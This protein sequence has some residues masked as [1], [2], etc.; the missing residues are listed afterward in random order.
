M[1]RLLLLFLLL[2]SLLLSAVGVIKRKAPKKDA[3]PD[4][5]EYFSTPMHEVMQNDIYLGLT[6]DNEYA[7]TYSGKGADMQ[8]DD[9]ITHADSIKLLTGSLEE[10]LLS[11][12]RETVVPVVNTEDTKFGG[13]KLLGFVMLQSV[14]PRKLSSRRGDIDFDFEEGGPAPIMEVGNI[15]IGANGDISSGAEEYVPP[16]HGGG[17]CITGRDCFHYNGT[18]TIKGECVCPS[19]YTGSYCQIFKSEKSGLATLAEQTKMKF[20]IKAGLADLQES[21]KPLN[22]DLPAPP[23]DEDTFVKIDTTSDATP[24]LPREGSDE[25]DGEDEDFRPAR[26]HSP[27]PKPPEPAEDEEMVPIKMKPEKKVKVKPKANK[28]KN[29]NKRGKK[30]GSEPEGEEDEEVE[31]PKKKKKQ[32]KKEKEKNLQAR[33]SELYGNEEGKVYPEP[34]LA[35]KVPGNIA[36]EREL[37]RRA[38]VEQFKFSIRFRTGPIGVTFNNMIPDGS[39]VESVAPGSQAQTSDIQKGDRLIAINDINVTTASAKNTMRVLQS[40][41]WPIVLVFLSPEPT[42]KMAELQAG[43]QRSRTFNMTVLYPPTMTG[44]YEVRLASWTPAVDMFHEESCTLYEIRA[45]GEDQFGCDSP[46][47]SLGVAPHLLEIAKTS[48]HVSSELEKMSPMGVLLFQEAI[49]RSITLRTKS[50]ALFKRGQCSFVQKARVA[51]GGGADLAVTV[52]TDDEL[53]D[54]PAGKENTTTCTVPM[55]ILKSSDG[56]LMQL[57]SLQS[58]LL[59]VVSDPKYGQSPACMQVIT[60]ADD[61]IDKWAHSVPHVPV[62]EIMSR[63]SEE[64]K[65]RGRAEEGGRVALSGRNGWSFFDYHLALFGSED[66]PLGPH[67]LSLAQPAHGCDPNAYENRISGTIVAILRGGGCSFG[68]KVINAQKLGAI[69]VMIVNTDDKATMRLMALPDEEPLI[70]IPVIMVSRRVQHYFESLLRMYHPID[71]HI[72]SI[73]PTGVFGGYE[74]SNQVVLPKRIKK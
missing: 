25:E 64:K 28:N 43:S 42:G 45:P 24:I 31:D 52:N 62:E 50:T 29:K 17:K 35:G 18:C 34:V 63:S 56:Y 37:M 65:L 57:T 53:M 41:Q 11:G 40:Q 5:L 4:K 73:Q 44:E 47:G 71:Q 60:M 70:Q 13:A 8:P 46:D 21:D 74:E 59:A 30:K 48:G 14:M 67:R 54:M 7:V 23:K 16:P 36:H 33:M 10:F 49:R 1:N 39:F 9:Y 20:K 26:D 6:A 66:V 58:E 51:A 22:P 12:V 27:P 61:I 15:R 32:V 38:S 72:V 19:N 2:S 3:S 69:A 55:G 68:I